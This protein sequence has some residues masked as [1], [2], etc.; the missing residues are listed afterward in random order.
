MA[1]HGGVSMYKYSRPSVA[2]TLMACL[3]QLFQNRSHICRF[4]VI[5]FFMLK[6]VYCVYS[7]E[8]PQ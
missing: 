7:L 1:R 3:S 4:R 5:F 8:T 6:M 2:R